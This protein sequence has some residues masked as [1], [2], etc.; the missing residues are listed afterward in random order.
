MLG[1][2]SNAHRI[3]GLIP[4]RRIKF[5]RRCRNASFPGD[6]AR[7]PETKLYQKPV[8]RW[9]NFDRPVRH[10]GRRARYEPVGETICMPFTGARMF[11]PVPGVAVS[12]NEAVVRLR[13]T[14]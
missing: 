1:W 13:N 3:C 8:Q 11:V 10:H 4:R 14:M 6:A 7:S 5:I 2:M 12:V 9:C